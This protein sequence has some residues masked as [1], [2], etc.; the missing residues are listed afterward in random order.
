[1][2]FIWKINEQCAKQSN[3]I[4]YCSNKRSN[5]VFNI[6]LFSMRVQSVYYDCKHLEIAVF[7]GTHLAYFVV[8]HCYI[9]NVVNLF[10]H[11][12]TLFAFFYK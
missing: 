10:K 2:I 5:N 11:N 9:N 3:N 6:R 7:L 12:D 1:M 4:K 8:L